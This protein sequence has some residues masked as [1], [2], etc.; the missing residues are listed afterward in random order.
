MAERLPVWFRQDMPDQGLMQGM[1]SRLTGARLHTIC[2]SA[3]CPNAGQCFARKTATFLILGDSCTRQCTFCAVNKGTPSPVDRE[4]PEH[5]LSVAKSLG[6]GYVVTTSVTRDD[7]P[8]GGAS[9][10]A[11]VVD[12]L[13][14]GGIKA[15]VLVPDFRGDC[16]SLR[17]VLISSPDVLNHNVETVPRLYAEV[18]PRADYRRSLELLARAKKIDPKTITKSGLMV[19]LGEEEGE[20]LAVMN[21]LRQSGCDLLTIG[22]YLQ[23]SPR[24]H[25][26]K[27]FVTPVEFTAYARKAEEMGFAAVASAPLVRSSYRAEE[28]FQTAVS[29][30]RIRVSSDYSAG[31]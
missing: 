3:H 5:I 18:R 15:E 25:A 14:G 29:I 13:H 2:Q 23:P 17:V 4:E 28:M 7:L 30:G 26:M 27:K 16:D 10:F 8:D 6:L 11:N 12:A 21:D 20:V 24:H 31:V 22:Q 1:D 19:G 9:H